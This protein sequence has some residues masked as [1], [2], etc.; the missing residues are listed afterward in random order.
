MSGDRERRAGQPREAYAAV[1]IDQSQ[2]RITEGP[3]AGVPP[4]LALRGIRMLT[5]RPVTPGQPDGWALLAKAV[6]RGSA[7]PFEVFMIAA[8]DVA[9][10]RPQ[11][12]PM[13]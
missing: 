3:A 7:W 8:L 2:Y 10:Q 4:G 13:L 6:P 12:E 9:A 5:V 1:W 11:A